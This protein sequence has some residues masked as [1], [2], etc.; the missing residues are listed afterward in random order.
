VIRIATERMPVCL[1]LPSEGSVKI[2]YEV[3]ATYEA[4]TVGT[5]RSS[6]WA[7]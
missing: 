4:N 5:Y 7:A 2:S 6:E 3:L 1:A